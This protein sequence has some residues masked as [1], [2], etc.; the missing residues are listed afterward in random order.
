MKHTR[1]LAEIVWLKNLYG[2]EMRPICMSKELIGPESE[3]N[4]KNNIANADAII[5]FGM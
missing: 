2:S 4:V 1:P 5:R 3:N